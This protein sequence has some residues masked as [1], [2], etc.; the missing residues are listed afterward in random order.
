MPSKHTRER[1]VVVSGAIETESGIPIA[2][3]DR[4]PGNGTTPV[5]RDDT[6][7]RMVLAYNHM[8]EREAVMGQTGQMPNIG[9]LMAYEN[10][11]LDEQETI[12][13]FQ[14]GVTNGWV[15]HLQGSYGRAATA[16]LESGDIHR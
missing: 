4:E 8:N 15:W 7:K 6:A 2:R 13:F 1:L 12:E 16:M 11:E 3:M 9:T 5:E 14:D 10:G